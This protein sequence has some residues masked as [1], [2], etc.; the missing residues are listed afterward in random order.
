MVANMTLLDYQKGI[1]RRHCEQVQV[2]DNASEIDSFPCI[3][4][5]G[6]LFFSEH[7]I[8]KFIRK[9]KKQ[10]SNSRL[11]HKM[12]SLHSDYLCLQDLQRIEQQGDQVLLFAVYYII[13]AAG[14]VSLDSCEPLLVKVNERTVEP[15]MLN[16]LMPQG[17][18]LKI[19][20][21][22]QVI[23][24]IN[25]WHHLVI[26]NVYY[27]FLFWMRFTIGRILRY[28][29][30]TLTSFS[31]NKW[32]IIRRFKFIGKNC[33]IHPD[34]RIELSVIGDNV[35][36][37]KGVYVL[38][39]I[40]GDDVTLD[41][42]TDVRFSVI[43]NKCSSGLESFVGMSVLYPGTYISMPGVQLSLLGRNTF[44]AGN[45]WYIDLKFK[46][47]VKVWHQGKRVQLKTNNMGVAV[48]NDCVIGLGNIIESGIEIP[49]GTFLVANPG[50]MLRGDLS[51][52]PKDIAVYVEDGVIKPLKRPPKK[53][54]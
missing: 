19:G 10:G 41:L 14:E 50:V 31:F 35:R 1:L 8:N 24:Q 25:H 18:T 11:A 3:I 32:N 21:S 5:E 23:F 9:A 7:I 17:Q 13:K 40:I 42:N 39:S 22:R 4:I 52:I 36:I 47:L 43:G 54:E 12:T 27:C 20:I 37:A 2:I 45:N 34:A 30:W 28:L 33:D 16:R 26:A 29:W 48:G 53:D 38:G 15:A 6:N 44:S 51:D 49:S 46:S